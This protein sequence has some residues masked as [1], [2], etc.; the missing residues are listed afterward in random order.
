MKVLLV[1]PTYGGISGSGRHVKLLHE[2]LKNKMNFE[3]W[4]LHTIGYIGVPK[5]KS[6]SFYIRCKL[7]KIPNDVDLIHIHNPKFIG[8]LDRRFPSILTIHGSYQQELVTQY[9]ILIKPL[10]K[11]IERRLKSV[12]VITCVDPYTAEKMNWRWIPNMIDTEAVEKISPDDHERKLLWIGRDDP[13]KNHELFRK[14]AKR[15]FQSYGIRS[16]AL[17]IRKGRYPS[18]EWISYDRVEWE[19]VISYLK[20]AYAL[21]ITSKVEGLPSTLLEAW[22]AKCP[23]VSVPL[24]SLK[25]L[26]EICGDILK[27]ANSYSP[28]DLYNIVAGVI[29]EKPADMIRRAYAIVKEKFDARIVSSKY[30]AIYESL[31]KR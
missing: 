6:L 2:F 9:G 15:V 4:S 31:L 11:Y 13:V 5:L 25:K 12:D 22:A 26:N 27:L 1:N 14:I 16:M 29:E 8:L 3:I 7:R 17:G 18:E 24:P 23:V 19:R 10:I 20:N 21:V 30:Y 28:E